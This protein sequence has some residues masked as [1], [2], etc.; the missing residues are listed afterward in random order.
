MR[1][2]QFARRVERRLEEAA[3][4][5]EDES[6]RLGMGPE[7]IQ[8]RAGELRLAAYLVREEAEVV[9]ETEDCG[10][11][12]SAVSSAEEP[13]LEA[14]AHFGERVHTMRINQNEL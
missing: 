11:E 9:S 8:N 2:Q 7:I 14:Q 10:L 5:A 6:R 1:H 12:G 4:R 13:P 3:R